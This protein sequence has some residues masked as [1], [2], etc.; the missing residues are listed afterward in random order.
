MPFPTPHE[1]VALSLFSIVPSRKSRTVIA[2]ERKDIAPSSS[3][4]HGG[5]AP[6]TNDRVHFI[7]GTEGKLW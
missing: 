3:D 5:D 4:R 1:Y 7:A 2:R 6:L